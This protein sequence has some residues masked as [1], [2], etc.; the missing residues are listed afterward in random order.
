MYSFFFVLSK[1]TCSPAHHLRIGHTPGAPLLCLYPPPPPIHMHTHTTWR[2]P[3]LRFP[4]PAACTIMEAREEGRRFAHRQAGC[5]RA[6]PSHSRGPCPVV[7]GCPAASG[8]VCEP[9]R[10]SPSYARGGGLLFP[11]TPPS[12]GGKGAR[13]DPHC[14]GA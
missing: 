5:K 10:A 3:H 1:S 7:W 8:I 13:G 2:H 12:C 4:P 14:L 6:R 9:A 11:Q